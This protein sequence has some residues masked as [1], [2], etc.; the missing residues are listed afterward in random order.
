MRNTL[1][2]LLASFLLSSTATA[3]SIPPTVYFS[4]SLPT[5]LEVSV[6]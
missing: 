6:T 1:A 4:S 3:N 5:N 2:G